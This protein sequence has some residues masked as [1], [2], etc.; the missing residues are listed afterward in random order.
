MS[1]S[2]TLPQQLY[3]CLQKQDLFSTIRVAL[4]LF[5]IYSC[6]RPLHLSYTDLCFFVLIY[7]IVK[8][9]IM[10]FAEIIRVVIRTH[11]GAPRHRSFEIRIRSFG[12]ARIVVVV[13]DYRESYQRK[14]ASCRFPPQTPWIRTEFPRCRIE[15]TKLYIQK[16]RTSSK[17]PKCFPEIL[18]FC[19]EP[20]PMKD[21]ARSKPILTDY[22]S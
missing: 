17:H 18:L 11:N 4:R 20:M 22:V 7:N 21:K 14:L 5:R 15:R 9:H 13:P 3:L 19:L 1:E 12:R 10:Y 16:V 8:H 2:E 6:A